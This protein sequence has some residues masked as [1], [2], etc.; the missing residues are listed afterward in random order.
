MPN[1]RSEIKLHN[2]HNSRPKLS[3]NNNSFEKQQ[4]SAKHLGQRSSRVMNHQ[5]LAEL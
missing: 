1:L 2:E 4:T 3:I 5:M